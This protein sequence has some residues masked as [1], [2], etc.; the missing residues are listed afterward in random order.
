MTA[1]LLNLLRDAARHEE[2]GSSDFDLN[3]GIRL[4]EGRKLRPGAVLIGV[5]SDDASVVLTKRAHHLRNHPGQ[6]AFPG[7]KVDAADKDVTAAALREAQEEIALDP[8]NVE[9]LGLLNPHE[10]VTGFSV[11]PV[12]ALINGA[13][14]FEPDPGEV[15]EVFRVPLSFLANPANF[16][17]EG[18][19]W[20]GIV[21]RYYVAPYGPYYIWG[22]TARMLHRLASRFAQ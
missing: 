22:A 17:I 15:D 9:I 19:R 20:Q 7:G 4:T 21:R 16:R 8:E 12:V 13:P 5:C 18:R 14:R 3:P 1:D 6:I 2:D 10:T 11:T